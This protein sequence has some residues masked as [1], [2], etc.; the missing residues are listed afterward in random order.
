MTIFIFYYINITPSEYMYHIVSYFY[1]VL[2][3]CCGFYKQLLK[4]LRKKTNKNVLKQKDKNKEVIACRRRRKE[5]FMLM[6]Q[7][8]VR[9]NQDLLT[10]LR[11]RNDKR[12]RRKRFFF[13]SSYF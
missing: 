9:R 10:E 11:K 2:C 7:Y 5:V 4:F 3:I 8:R 6:K 12:K 13:V 1:Q